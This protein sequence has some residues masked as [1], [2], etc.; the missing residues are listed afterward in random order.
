M[1]TRVAI[2]DPF[3]NKLQPDSV[4][5]EKASCTRRTHVADKLLILKKLKLAERVGFVPDEPATLTI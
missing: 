3:V 4:G 2:A 1:C 5:E